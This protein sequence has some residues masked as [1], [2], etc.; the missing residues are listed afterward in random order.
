A[1]T[2]TQ[3][4]NAADALPAY[5]ARRIFFAETSSD[6][7]PDV[8]PFNASAVESFDRLCSTD[9][10]LATSA[11]VNAD[12]L[13]VS[14]AQAVD[15]LRGHD[16][17]EGTALRTR[18]K[19]LGDIVNSTPVVSSPR[20]NY[21]YRSLMAN[22]NGGQPANDPFGYAEYMETKAGRATMVYVGANDGMLH[23][24]NHSNGGESFAYIPATSIGHMANLL[25]PEAADFEHRYYVDGPISVSDAYYAGGWHTVLVG[26][27]GAGGRSVF[28]LQVDNPGSFGSSHVL[29][30]VNDR[31]RSGGSKAAAA[32]RIG[33]VTSR[34]LIAPVR[35][36][37]GTVAWKAIFGNGFG[38][39]IGAD[40]TV[41]LFVVD[42]GTGAISYIDA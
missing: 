33:H 40:G 31:M 21:G 25:F 32:R 30:E 35:A 3:L 18:S 2:R 5:G 38:S 15:Y 41:T 37:D 27:S 13:G 24:F 19:K 39:D 12:K 6:S 11:C 20:D 36:K 28:G 10:P 34:P 9:D 23:A 29:W 7:T 42:I 1:L 22:P 26:T 8:S 17:L 16:A 4:W 14:L